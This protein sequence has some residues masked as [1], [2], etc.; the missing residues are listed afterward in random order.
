M[1]EI[2][3][4]MP[5][6]HKNESVEIKVTIGKNRKTEN[7]RI[8]SF[9]WDCKDELS[10]RN[11]STSISLARISRLKKSIESYDKSWELIQIFAPL[12]NSEIIQVMYRKKE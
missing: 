8:E 2:S 9:Q 4:P 6:L 11:D 7:Y 3:L 12:E 10:E 1:R 5:P